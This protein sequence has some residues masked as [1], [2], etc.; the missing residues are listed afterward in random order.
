[1]V[2]AAFAGIDGVVAAGAAALA[3]TCAKAGVAS[4]IMAAAI[5]GR[6]TKDISTLLDLKDLAEDPR[7]PD[8]HNLAV[9]S[10]GELPNSRYLGDLVWPNRGGIGVNH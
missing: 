7:C 9:E 2:G 8:G 5:K 4:A 10:G 1:M 6:N 3:G